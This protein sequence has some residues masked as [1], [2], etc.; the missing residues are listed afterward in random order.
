M[1][2][3]GINGALQQVYTSRLGT[4]HHEVSLGPSI[5]HGPVENAMREMG[6][7]KATVV[8][9]VWTCGRMVDGIL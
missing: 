5:K 3:W 6:L 4:Q 2:P 9:R 1:L 8:D 7:E